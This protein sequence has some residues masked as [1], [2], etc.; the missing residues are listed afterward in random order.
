M[1]TIEEYE[2]YKSTKY[3]SV[4]LLNDQLSFHLKM[5]FDP[6][7]RTQS[8]LATI[9]GNIQDNK[10]NPHVDLHVRYARL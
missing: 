2:I 10:T 6:L 5:I 8:P 1:T 4:N 7:I 9:G 3:N